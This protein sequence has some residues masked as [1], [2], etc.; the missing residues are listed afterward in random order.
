MTFAATNGST[1]LGIESVLAVYTGSALTN[2]SL[3]ASNCNSLD[4]TC[5]VFSA[6]SNTT[7][8]VAVAGCNGTMRDFTL[9]WNQALAPYFVRQPYSSNVIAGESVTLSAQAIGAPL[10]SYQWR[11]EGTN[12]LSATNT[13]YTITNVQTS[14]MTN[15]VLVV[16]NAFG[17]LTS[18]VAGLF[19]KPTGS[20]TMSLWQH[21]T[22]SQ[23]LFH[24]SGVTN[25]G[26]V[27]QATTNLTN[28]TPLST[29]FVS[30]DFTNGVTTNFPYRFF[31]ALY[32]E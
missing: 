30:F 24:V 1:G 11:L 28:W 29:N 26:Y 18:S 3:V 15:Y 8:R 5:V 4:Q 17:S 31:R 32:Q 2:L 16:T 27:V 14:H 22:N 9:Y 10:L 23:F 25:R 6:A 21:T 20:A 13:S 7:Y 19:V 12:L